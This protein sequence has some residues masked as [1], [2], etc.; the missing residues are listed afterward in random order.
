MAKKLRL[1]L[2]DES[3]YRELLQETYY[4][5]ILAENELIRQIGVLENSVSLKDVIMEDV[6]KYMKALNDFYK[7]KDSIIAKKIAI[8]QQMQQY[9]VK[10][11]KAANEDSEGAALPASFDM[12]EMLKQMKEQKDS[13][14][15]YTT[16]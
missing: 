11:S 2:N 3:S 15:T 10:S 4:N 6:V 16:K 14:Q 9:L 5:A 8:A 1:Q 7:S 13:P 12:A